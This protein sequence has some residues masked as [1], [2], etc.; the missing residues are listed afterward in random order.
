MSIAAVVNIEVDEGSNKNVEFSWYDNSTDLPI[1]LDGASAIMEVK[2]F[3]GSPDI[4]LTFTT[5]DSSI[6][7]GGSEGTI[8]VVIKPENTIDTQWYQGV[9]DL[10]IT[11]ADGDVIRFVK[12]KFIILKRVT[13]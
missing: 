4:L 10:F 5:A 8:L 6:I 1:N 9:Y 2:E 12:G 13:V 3:Y 7:L 11:K